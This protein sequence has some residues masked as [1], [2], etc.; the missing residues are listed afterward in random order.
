MR[1]SLIAFGLLLLIGTA[2]W[3][4]HTRPA[5]V[6]GCQ[7]SDGRFVVTAAYDKAKKQWQFTWKDAK[8]NK[9]HTGPLVGVADCQQGHFDVCYI[10]LFV[11]PDGETFA[12]WNP[13]GWAGYHRNLPKVPER[14]TP[15]FKNYVGFNDR[16]VV[17]KKTGEIVKRLAIGDFLKDKEWDHVHFVQG[18]LYWL[19]ESP[20]FGP[21]SIGEP[22]RMGYRYY[23]VS[24]DYTVLEVY[25]APDREVQAKFKSVGKELALTSRTV[26]VDLTTGAFL[27][28]DGKASAPNKTPVKGYAGDFGKRGDSMK[29][30]VPSLDPVRIAG[31]YRE[32]SEQK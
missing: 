30:F 8:E 4:G 28:E 20:D 14:D 19:G 26:R 7:S 29:F 3:A 25:I 15:E 32:G 22:P 16:L 2:V 13:T 5:Y 21:K 18:N 17:Y 10:H 11:A 1:P 27:A 24:P 9:T 6:D 31:T 23:R 12:A